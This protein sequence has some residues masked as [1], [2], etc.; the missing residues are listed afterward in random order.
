LVSSLN[1]FLQLFLIKLETVDNVF[2]LEL[3][4]LE[5]ALLSEIEAGVTVLS[6]SGEE[7]PSLQDFSACSFKFSKDAEVKTVLTLEELST[8]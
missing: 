4:E 7:L 1:L 8:G 2:V 5:D 3:E 6:E